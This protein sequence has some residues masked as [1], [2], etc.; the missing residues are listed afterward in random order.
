MKYTND[1]FELFVKVINMIVY[2]QVKW[3][4]MSEHPF[5]NVKCNL[6]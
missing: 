6:R 1:E 2:K 3:F 5:V 4:A